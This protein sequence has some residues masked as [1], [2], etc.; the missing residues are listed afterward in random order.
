M[1]TETDT[2]AMTQS[3]DPWQPARAGSGVDCGAWSTVERGA[4]C[5]RTLYLVATGIY[6]II[7]TNISVCA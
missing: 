1:P 3:A 5:D 6:C 4:N 2:R 7:Y